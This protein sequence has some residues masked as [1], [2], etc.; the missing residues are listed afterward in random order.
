[1]LT[2]SENEFGKF[3]EISYDRTSQLHIY[4]KSIGHSI[5]VQA[6]TLALEPRQAWISQNEWI[7][8]VLVVSMAL[9]HPG[10]Y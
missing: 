5:K 8:V 6:A 1:M 7:L 3:L 2:V 4:R 9:L 10:L